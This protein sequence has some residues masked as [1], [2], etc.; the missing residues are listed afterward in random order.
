MPKQYQKVYDFAIT[1][2]SSMNELLREIGYTRQPGTLFEKNEEGVYPELPIRL[3]DR[4]ME[5]YNLSPDFFQAEGYKPL[6]TPPANVNEWKEA[7]R[8]ARLREVISFFEKK[9]SLIGLKEIANFFGVSPCNLSGARNGKREYLSDEFFLRVWKAGGKI[10]SLNWLLYGVGKKFNEEL[11]AA[12]DVGKD[13]IIKA[14][15]D[16]IGNKDTYIKTLEGYVEVLKEK[17]EGLQKRIIAL[18]RPTTPSPKRAQ[19]GTLF[20]NV[21]E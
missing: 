4:M 8:A 18:E 2:C 7:E 12:E 13:E 21:V 14:L 10:Y 11:L 15:K 16:T 6:L 20:A 17:N 1:Q 3:K 5:R 19:N 9:K